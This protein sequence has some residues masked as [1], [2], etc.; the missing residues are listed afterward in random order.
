[1]RIH[2]ITPSVDYNWCL[3][4]LDTQQNEPTY[5]NS[6]K[7]PKVVKPTNKKSYYNKQCNKQPNVPSLPEYFLFHSQKQV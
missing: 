5:Q 7:V 1:M 4:R 6:I 2:K 3:K